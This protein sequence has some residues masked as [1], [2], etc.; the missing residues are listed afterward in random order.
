[1]LST[2]GTAAPLIDAAWREQAAILDDC[3]A[4]APALVASRGPLRLAVEMEIDRRGR[5]TSATIKL[6]AAMSDETLSRC[7]A[8]A[9]ETGLRLPPPPTARPTRARTELL[10]GFSS[11]SEP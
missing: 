10:I 9:I 11:K 7:L 4:G 3:L 1:V 5:I 6:P 8:R 2:G